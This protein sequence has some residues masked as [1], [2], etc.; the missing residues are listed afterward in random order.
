MKTTT[1]LLL[2]TFAVG[3][4]VQAEEPTHVF[5]LI[6]QSNMAGRA[7]IEDVDKEP[8][9]GA[10]LWNVAERKWQPA[11]PPYNLFSP[12]RKAVGM[13]RLNCGPSFVREYR[14]SNPDCKVGIVCVARGGTRIEQWEKG[15][16]KPWSLYDTAVAA[17]KSALADGKGQLKGILWHQGEGNS[18]RPL[19]YLPLLRELVQNLRADLGAPRVPFV[20]SQLG[21]WR[22]KYAA[23]NRM[24]I[25]QPRL[26]PAPLARIACVNT[27]GLTAFDEAHFD[28]ASQ[29]TLGERYA[30]EMVRLLAADEPFTAA[31]LGTF[32]QPL[33]LPRSVGSGPFEFEAEVTLDKV[34]WT[35]ASVWF[36]KQFN[37]GLDGRAGGMFF[38]IPRVGSVQD[39]KSTN[40][41]VAAKQPF[42]F[43]AV[44]YTHLRAQD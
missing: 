15:L 19:D 1:L 31:D 23:F 28:S 13:Q 32:K 20:F 22:A 21:P 5:L 4:M 30:T 26:V 11:A 24:I 43:S 12:H 3:P 6:G 37:F 36:G 2:A 44:S 17:T 40:G 7:T 29:R 25:E 38:E 16:Q 18:G 34:D 27:A 42:R 41:K 33:T 39:L 9:D 35:A 14:K 8:I 10:M